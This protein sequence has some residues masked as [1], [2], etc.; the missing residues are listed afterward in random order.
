MQ[1]GQLADQQRIQLCLPC[2]P[3][4]DRRERGGAGLGGIGRRP[5]LRPS[6][7]G[8]TGQGFMGS[9]GRG[10]GDALGKTPSMRSGS[11]PASV[12]PGGQARQGG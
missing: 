4:H 5:G 9:G 3:V 6:R 10:A 7:A 12:L 11:G 8:G 1:V 2:S